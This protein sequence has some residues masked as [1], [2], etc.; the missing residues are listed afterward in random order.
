VNASRRQ[1]RR[2]RQLVASLM[3]LG[4]VT[5]AAWWFNSSHFHS[6]VRAQ[7]VARLEEATGGHSEIGRIEWNLSKLEFVFY[8][9][10]VHGREPATETP[11]AQ[12]DRIYLRAKVLSLLRRQVGVRYLEADHPV[13]HVITFPD[14]T[15]NQPVP[16][17][18]LQTADVQQLFDLAADRME[19][20]DGV[21][22]LN[23]RNIPLDVAARDTRVVLTYVR[24]QNRY[25]GSISVGSLDAQYLNFRPLK[26]QAEIDFSVLP[27]EV[28]FTRCVLTSGHSQIEVRGTLADFREP[29]ITATFSALI[30][31]QQAGEITRSPQLR[32]GTATVRGDA[33]YHRGSYRATGTLSLRDAGYSD[34]TITLSHATAEAKFVADNSGISVNGVR[35]RALGGTF[36]GEGRIEVAANPARGR[37][38][39]QRGK[40]HLSFTGIDA[41]ALQH[42]LSSHQLRALPLRGAAEGTVD[43][44]WAGSAANATTTIAMNVSPPAHTAPGELPLKAT[45]RAEYDLRTRALAISELQL[46]SPATAVE[47]IGALG[48]RTGALQ[49]DVKS[50]DFHELQSL[51]TIIGLDLNLP[52]AVRGPTT[53]NGT[54]TGNLAAPQVNGHLVLNDFDY[55]ASAQGPL[56]AL[57]AAKVPVAAEPHSIPFDHFTGDVQYTGR[58]LSIKDGRL[59]F[60]NSSITIS[61]S[62]ALIDGK[63]ADAS[64]IDLQFA[65]QNE[66]A[67]RMQAIIGT[68]YPVAGTVNGRFRLR[69]T[70]GSPLGTGDLRLNGDIYG[71]PVTASANIV[72]RGVDVELGDLVLAQNG[73][74]VTGTV[75]YN[76]QSA[77]FRFNL[78]G[79]SIS[80][81]RIPFLQRPQLS[82]AGLLNFTA[83]GSGT[84]GAPLLKASGHISN[85][86]LNGGSL[87]EVKFDAVTEGEI[88]RVVAATSATAA[89]MTVRGTVRLR[90]DFPAE[91]HTELARFDFDPFLRA[92]LPQNVAMHARAAGT[93]DLTGPLESPKLMTIAGDFIQFNVWQEKFALANQGP[94]RFR[95]ANNVLS[96]DTFHL[97]GS[98]TD[99]T[100]GG[101]F[102][103][104]GDHALNAHADGTLDLR[105][106]HT[107]DPGFSSSGQIALTLRASGTLDR[108]SLQGQVQI[109]N[110]N[111]SYVE[112][113]N[114]LADVNGTLVFTND[115]LQIQSL[116]GH[117]GGGDVSMTGFIAYQ[118]GIFL[119]I[120]AQ[121]QNMRLRYPQG[122]SSV[123]NADLRLT[124][125]AQNPLLSGDLLLTRFGVNP[126]FD[127]ALYLARMKLPP[128]INAP[129]S[130]LNHLRFDLHVVSVPQ[131]RVS[132]SLAKLSGD[133]DLRIRGVASKP[134]V[135]GRINIL[136]GE[137]F[138]NGTKYQLQ[139][140]DISFLNPTV[141]QPVLN[142]D[143]T[144]RIS[145][146][147]I[148]LSMHGPT[149]HLHTTYRSEPPLPTQDVIAL[150]AF[151]QCPAS[152]E[153]S[154]SPTAIEQAENVSTSV[155]KSFT[156]TASNQI[157]GEALNAELS[158]RVQRLFGISRV[159]I[160]PQIGTATSNPGARVTIE[161][162]VSSKMTITYITDVA[163]ASQQ[164]IQV[165]YNLNRSV[166]LVAVRDQFGVISLDVRVRRLKR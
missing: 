31:L 124:G 47:A 160:S 126:N 78:R 94:V 61:G 5:L 37:P 69:G 84:A 165:E 154:C 104:S 27:R 80:L 153:F 24:H 88:M 102:S 155:N 123:A 81:A 26:A 72:L 7:L 28:Q 144:T 82:T 2:K 143:I 152:A 130:L 1:R 108:P 15:T 64:A 11:F 166:S 49:L 70:L 66:N 125:S 30:N 110:G 135:L 60:R 3:L 90:G 71:Q 116:R 136:E 157:L 59:Q 76:L 131:L 14:G 18:R 161:Q 96:L 73:S 16:V 17:Q 51:L 44:R 9:V 48:T 162:Q 20:H 58:G 68:S 6:W 56:P 33:V 149:D 133:V 4:L 83:E 120:A 139:R 107:L 99:L 41:A 36:T 46:S 92:Y 86:V 109:T 34:A 132:M 43:A 164:V 115:R 89:E 119:N 138:F 146:Y 12:V 112:L 75:A 141:V 50:A 93:V 151:R 134:V 163:Q 35:G 91:I 111:V 79:D 140:G 21:L 105:L 22:L 10:T 98:H 87:G 145:G 129:D 100:G 118:R 45:L 106:L 38:A 52:I 156:E 148:T 19:V 159:R 103:L 42:S 121:A 137:I 127:F 74:R 53:F 97:L 54:V 114:G 147:D 77:A 158:N 55:L 40:A 32:S 23:E 8:D 62:V 63:P 95:L 65:L 128:A 85:L 142:M 29:Q 25:D 13:I 122:V 150:L 67:T 117:S 113:P 57:R 101:T 39:P